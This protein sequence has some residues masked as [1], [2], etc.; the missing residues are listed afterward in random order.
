M[1]QPGASDLGQLLGCPI[2]MGVPRLEAPRSE[3]N[4]E[5]FAVCFDV[6]GE[7]GGTLAV[8]VPESEMDTLLEALLGAPDVERADQVDDTFKV[9]AADRR[10]VE[11]ETAKGGDHGLMLHEFFECLVMLA[12]Q[13]ANPKFG[14]VGHNDEKAVG[15]PLPGCLESMVKQK[16]LVNAKRDKL[17][18]VRASLLTDKDVAAAWATF[19]A[20]LQKEFEKLAAGGLARVGDE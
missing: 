12:F 4:P 10:V 7:P 8:L 15:A 11:G 14:E 9:S 19:K 1:L 13:I 3:A 2:H 16:L 20:P 17:A 6:H 5:G 18:L